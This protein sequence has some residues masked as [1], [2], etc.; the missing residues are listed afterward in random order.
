[1]QKRLRNSKKNEKALL[2]YWVMYFIEKGIFKKEKR[3]AE[4]AQWQ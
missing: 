1:V 3:K 4:I 2:E